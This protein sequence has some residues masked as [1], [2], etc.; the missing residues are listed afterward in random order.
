MHSHL[1][2][3]CS[4]VSPVEVFAKLAGLALVVLGNSTLAMLANRLHVALLS[5]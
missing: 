5:V 2:R 1:A 4:R 3:A